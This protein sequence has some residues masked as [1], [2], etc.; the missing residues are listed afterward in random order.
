MKLGKTALA[1]I[2]GTVAIGAF[3]IWRGISPGGFSTDHIV[4]VTVPELTAQAAH[5][6]ALFA[7]NCAACHGENAGGSKQGPPLIHRIYKPNHHGDQAFLIA[8][9]QGVRAHHWAFGNMPPVDGVSSREIANITAYVR[10]VQ[11]A[12][13]IF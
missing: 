10:E 12:N 9:S 3:L 13:G 7:E 4:D 1:F 5:G 6:E 2:L 11:K 8:A